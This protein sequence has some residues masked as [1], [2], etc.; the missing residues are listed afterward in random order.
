MDAVARAG[1]VVLATTEVKDSGDTNVLGG[2]DTLRTLHARAAYSGFATDAGGVIRRLDRSVDG[3]ETMAVAA[4]P[5]HVDRSAFGSGG[6]WIDY[7]GP[8]GTVPTVSFSDL[9]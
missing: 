3:L 9:L 5:R 1:N 8:P 2:E 6:A 7:A 4:A